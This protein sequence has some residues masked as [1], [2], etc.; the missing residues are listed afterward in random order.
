MN[1]LEVRG[2]NVLLPQNRGVSKFDSPF[3]KYIGYFTRNKLN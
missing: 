3:S 2:R 1:D